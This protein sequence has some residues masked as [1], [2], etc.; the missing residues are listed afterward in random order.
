MKKWIDE[1]NSNIIIIILIMILIMMYIIFLKN[2]K[3]LNHGPW[4][5]GI[6]PSVVFVKENKHTLASKKTFAKLLDNKLA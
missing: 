6:H 4:A 3:L 2:I 1:K 5:M